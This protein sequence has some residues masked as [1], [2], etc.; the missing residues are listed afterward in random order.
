MMFIKH[1]YVILAVLFT[2]FRNDYLLSLESTDI[3]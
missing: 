2:S 1:H 3:Q